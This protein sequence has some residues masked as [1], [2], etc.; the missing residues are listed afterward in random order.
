MEVP[1]VDINICPECSHL[2]TN[3]FGVEMGF[4]FSCLDYDEPLVEFGICFICF[5]KLGS[6]CALC[7][8]RD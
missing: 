6:L 4:V 7:D 2:C 3:C 5:S 1:I 8:G